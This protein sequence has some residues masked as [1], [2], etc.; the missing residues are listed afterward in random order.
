MNGPMDR[1]VTAAPTAPV[2]PQQQSPQAP[3]TERKPAQRIASRPKAGEQTASE[4]TPLPCRSPID[5]QRPQ[6]TVNPI[7]V[8]IRSSP[9]SSRPTTQ[10]GKPGSTLSRSGGA[11]CD[12]RCR[13]QISGRFSAS[14][15]STQPNPRPDRTIRH[16]NSLWRHSAG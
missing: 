5:G 6:P 13:R 1:A 10:T 14:Q 9:K 8:P 15:N 11:Y 16:P 4:S 7:E 3:Y 2:V 12:E